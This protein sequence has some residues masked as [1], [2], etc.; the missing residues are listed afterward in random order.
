MWDWFELLCSLGRRDKIEH[1]MREDGLT[2]QKQGFP[3]KLPIS[4][5]IRTRK[6]T[7]KGPFTKESLTDILLVVF[8]LSIAKSTTKKES[9]SKSEKQVEKHPGKLK[10]TFSWHP[11]P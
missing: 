10:E 8:G 3:L 11:S 6:D 7:T 5:K 2:S 1:R 4:L 9:L